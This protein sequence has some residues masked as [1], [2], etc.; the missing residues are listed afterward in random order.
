[1]KCLVSKILQVN[2]VS[3]SISF[4]SCAEEVKLGC[5]NVF[6][7]TKN[8]TTVS[9]ALL[10]KKPEGGGVQTLGLPKCYIIKEKTT[11][12]INI[13]KLHKALLKLRAPVVT[14]FIVRS[15]FY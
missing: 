6:L 12:Y 3:K 10:V 14:H 13:N 1:M 8:Q 9:P 15:Y 5:K 7:S 11:R 2:E 4:S